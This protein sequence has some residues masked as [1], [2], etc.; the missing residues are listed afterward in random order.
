[1]MQRVPSRSILLL[2]TD[3][4]TGGGVNRVIVDLAGLLHK[5]LGMHVTISN[6]RSDRPSSYEIP[7]D[8][9]LRPGRGSGIL[10]YL[11]FLWRLRSEPFDTIVSFWGQ[12][13]ILALLMLFR[14]GKRIVVCEHTS[15]QDAPRSVRLGR[16]ILYRFA[17]AVTVLNRRELTHYTRY[18][19]N[20]TLVPNPIRPLHRAHG[21]REKI[22][23][24]VGHL[25]ERKGFADLVEAYA[26]SGLEQKGWALHIIGKGPEGARLHTMINQLGLTNAEI[27][28]PSDDIARIY[29]LA[30]IIVIPSQIEVFSLVLAEG[31]LAGLIPLAYDNDGPAYLLERFLELIVPAGNVSILAERLDVLC[32]GDAPDPADVAR[33]IGDLTDPEVV[34]RHWRSLLA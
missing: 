33:V 21:K 22:I 6:A 31:A 15:F 30:R 7:E 5:R 32:S 11:Q 16:W 13:N 1:M 29:G 25:V 3:L 20:V 14:S 17:H 8:V 24:G 18:L 4:S 23:L 28:P 19:T 27:R 26:L 9:A 12:D 34:I 2:G 10:Q